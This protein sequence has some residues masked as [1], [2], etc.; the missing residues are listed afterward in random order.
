MSHTVPGLAWDAALKYTKAKLDTLYDIEIHQ[1]LERGM[2]GG[3]SMISN[4]YAKA[5]NKYL[6]EY[7]PERSSSYIIYGDKNNL[8]G[9]AMVQSLPVGDF[10]CINE[11]DIQSFDVMSLNDEADT[12]YI[13]EVDLEYPIALHNLHSD[14]PLAPEKMLIFHDM[15]SP[16]QQELTEELGYKP[17]KVEKLVLNLWDKV[18]YPVQYRNLKFYLTQGLK[19]RKI[20]RALQFKQEASLKPYIDLNTK[21]RAAV[22]NDFEKDFFKLMNNSVFGK[23][24]ED[25]RKRVNIKLVTEPSIFK[26]HVA[27]VTY[28]RSEVFVNNEEK[29]EYFVGVEKTRS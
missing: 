14:Y 9:E 25:V 29:Q 3:I 8:Y 28:K 4:R 13:L 17:A 11:K 2:R 21:L 20:H 26:K 7:D 16:Y 18:K 19:L 24:M 23:T 5:N 12:G 15:L 1:F 10:K 6:Q 22:T 27:K